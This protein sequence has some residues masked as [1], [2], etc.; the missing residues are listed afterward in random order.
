MFICYIYMFNGN[1]YTYTSKIAIFE[2]YNLYP[3][4]RTAGADKSCPVS[5]KYQ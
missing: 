3:E 5:H 1:W 4:I 2:V